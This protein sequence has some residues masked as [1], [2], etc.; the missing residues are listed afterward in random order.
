MIKV[1]WDI[2]LFYLLYGV[3]HVGVYKPEEQVSKRSALSP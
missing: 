3:W 2:F 1:V